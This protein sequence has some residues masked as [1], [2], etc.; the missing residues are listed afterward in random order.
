MTFTYALATASPAGTDAI[1]LGD[2]NIR[3]FKSAMTERVNSR[4]V[5]VNADPWIIKSPP[6]GSGNSQSMIPTSDNLYVLGETARRWADVRS[7]NADFSGSV[8]NQTPSESRVTTG[9]K[10]YLINNAVYNSDDYN[11][12]GN[13]ATDNTAA[14][15][16][17]LA[18]MPIAG[19]KFVLAKGIYIISNVVFP[20]FTSGLLMEGLGGNRVS[21]FKHKT[22]ATANMFTAACNLEIR[23]IGFTE[24]PANL[25]VEANRWSILKFNGNTGSLHVH[26]CYFTGTA[27]SC[28][29]L[30]QINQRVSIHDN[31]FFNLSDWPGTGSVLQ[32]SYGIHGISTFASTGAVKIVYNNFIN[33]APVG[34]AT[35]PCGFQMDFAPAGLAS[36]DVSHN[37]LIH[38][39]GNR[40]STQPSGPLDVYQFAD[41]ATYSFNRIRFSG[42]GGVRIGNT[43]NLSIEGNKIS[44][45]LATNIVAAIF[46]GNFVRAPAIDYHNVTITGN[47]VKN[48]TAGYLAGPGTGIG[49]HI[50]GGATGPVTTNSAKRWTIT[51]NIVDGCGYGMWMEGTGDVIATGNQIE[52]ALVY[53]IQIVKGS[54]LIQIHGGSINNGSNQPIHVDPNSNQN[55]KLVIDGV[56]FQ[57]NSVY[58]GPWIE[59]AAGLE[60]PLVVCRNCTMSDTAINAANFKYIITLEWKNNTCMG[61]PMQSSFVTNINR[62]GSTDDMLNLT[63]SIALMPSIAAGATATRSDTVAGA[64]LG[65]RVLSSVSVDP[66]GLDFRSQV[67]ALNTVRTLVT[68]TTG[69]PIV[70]SGNLFIT[71]LK[72]G[73]P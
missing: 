5:D 20:A 61:L 32:G 64:A 7:V 43:N 55:L 27:F 42:C 12:V 62:W 56:S 49:I 54:G 63:V 58:S 22:G 25:L 66:A 8:T 29:E 41:R 44:D 33:G 69:A 18:A 14:F 37:E 65:D 35:Q 53:G 70:P 1:S 17:L 34:G 26:D 38:F 19:G 2:D 16:A 68:N 3:D 36:L 15:T 21:M 46:V 71:V 39:G 60:I 6:G 51:G 59:G 57:G 13:N 52:G 73:L 31:D 30:E 11:M 4:F 72:R 48:W 24:D 50:F 40:G 47:V 9:L 45:D 10:Q 23:G 67:S 28:V